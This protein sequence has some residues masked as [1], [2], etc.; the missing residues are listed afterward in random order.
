MDFEENDLNYIKFIHRVVVL[1]T[2]IKQ[3]LQLDN[4]AIPPWGNLKC[5]HTKLFV[6]AAS[7]T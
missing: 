4:I 3:K 7:P 5:A 6:P 1:E 2:M